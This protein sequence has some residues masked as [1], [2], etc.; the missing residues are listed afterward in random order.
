MASFGPDD[1][2]HRDSSAAVHARTRLPP[3]YGRDGCA[4]RCGRDRLHLARDLR[5]R[6][7]HALR[8][9]RH[10][11]GQ[12]VRG[13]PGR[14]HARFGRRCPPG[15][16]R[17]GG[18]EAGPRRSDR[19]RCGR[20]LRARPCRSEAAAPAAVPVASTAAAGTSPAAGRP[21]PAVR[22]APVAGLLP[23]PGPEADRRPRW[24]PWHPELLPRHRDQHPEPGRQHRRHQPL[25]QSR[26]GRRRHR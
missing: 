21:R 25:R 1:D 7:R 2:A 3:G 5:G 26:R 11:H 24:H 19:G 9:Q 8:G 20:R 15:R 22:P 12:C 14:R 10:E 23:D 4:D 18:R 13:R 17:R 6:Q 16:A